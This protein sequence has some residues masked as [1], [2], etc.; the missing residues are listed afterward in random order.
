MLNLQHLLLYTIVFYCYI[1]RKGRKARN[2]YIGLQDWYV[3][4][5]GF[6]SCVSDMS[7]MCISSIHYYGC[8]KDGVIGSSLEDEKDIQSRRRL[9][10]QWDDTPLCWWYFVSLLEIEEMREITKRY[11]VCFYLKHSLTSRL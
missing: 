1:A 2:E 11:V 4:I 8:T 10:L 5:F 7:K 3:R 9:L 6:C